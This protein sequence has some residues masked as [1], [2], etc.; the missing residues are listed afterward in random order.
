MLLRS[1][2]QQYVLIPSQVVKRTLQ[3]IIEWLGRDSMVHEKGCAPSL[4]F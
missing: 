2:I 4:E 3:A 1:Q